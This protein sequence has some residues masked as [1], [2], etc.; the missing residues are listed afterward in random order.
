MRP[1]HSPRTGCSSHRSADGPSPLP[2]G[3]RRCATACE[4]RRARGP[5]RCPCRRSAWSGGSSRSQRRSARTFCTALPA[6]TLSTG[7]FTS[8]AKKNKKAEQ[9]A[10]LV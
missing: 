6:P 5:L 9:I 1:L 7:K 4:R 10:E 8:V 3:Q 2:R